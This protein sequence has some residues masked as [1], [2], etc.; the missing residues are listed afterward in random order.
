VERLIEE[1]KKL[2]LAPESP[3][4][5]LQALKVQRT[6]DEHRIDLAKELGITLTGRVL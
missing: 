6:L 3:E 4:Q 2:L 5:E 1:N